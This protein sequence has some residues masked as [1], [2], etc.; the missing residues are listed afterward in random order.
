M[1]TIEL[2]T[3]SGDRPTVEV[4]AALGGLAL[5]RNP[6]RNYWTISH[7]MSGYRVLSTMDRHVALV[8]LARLNARG[9]DWPSVPPGSLSAETPREA[10][11]WRAAM[12][13]AP[14]RCW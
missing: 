9:T 14:G 11:A 8:A 2:A 7:E 5:H 3:R 4:V 6:G 1:R 10:A 12:D 13:V